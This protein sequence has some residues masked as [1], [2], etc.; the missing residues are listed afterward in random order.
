M[1]GIL[2]KIGFSSKMLGLLRVVF[3]VGLLR[4]FALIFHNLGQKLV[5][6]TCAILL[7]AFV[8]MLTCSYYLY[9]N[10]FIARMSLVKKTLLYGF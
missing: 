10:K 5:A 6:A 7:L 3:F 8:V 9:L 1:L 2:E 4:F